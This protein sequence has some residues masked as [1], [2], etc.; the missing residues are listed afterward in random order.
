MLF[1]I[2]I[3]DVGD[4]AVRTDIHVEETRGLEIVAEPD[5]PVVVAALLTDD[6]D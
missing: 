5:Q 2:R 4:Q 1:L 6:Q 3:D